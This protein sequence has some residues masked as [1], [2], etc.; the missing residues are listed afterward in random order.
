MSSVARGDRYLRVSNALVNTSQRSVRR[1]NDV[2][3]E[4]E[5]AL[6]LERKRLGFMVYY[7]RDLNVFGGEYWFVLPSSQ[8]TTQK[9]TSA[10][11]AIDEAM[12]L[13][14]WGGK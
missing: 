3:N 8:G 10:Q 2:V 7:G 6:E 14:N 9:H 11:A 13:I 5:D 1:V 4:L 12:E